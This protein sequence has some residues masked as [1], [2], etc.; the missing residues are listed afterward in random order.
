MRGRG[1]GAEVMMV[2][3]LV[4]VEVDRP[5]KAMVFAL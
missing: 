5:S 1:G 3:R 2:R 4:D